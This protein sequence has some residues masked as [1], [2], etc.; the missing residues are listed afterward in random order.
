[1]VSG[2][3]AKEMKVIATGAGVQYESSVAWRK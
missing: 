2:N 3:L 1:M